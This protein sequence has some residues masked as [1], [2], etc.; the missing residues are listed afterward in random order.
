MPVQHTPVYVTEA[1]RLEQENAARQV[2]DLPDQ[3][4]SRHGQKPRLSSSASAS[5]M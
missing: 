3:R 2:R 1:E 5:V 4:L